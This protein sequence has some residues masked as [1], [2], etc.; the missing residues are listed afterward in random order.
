MNGS[1]AHHGRPHQGPRMDRAQHSRGRKENS[2]LGKG[3]EAVPTTEELRAAVFAHGT[4]FRS[5]EK[6]IVP[7]SRGGFTFGYILKPVPRNHCYVD[8]TAAINA[9]HQEWRVPFAFPF[10]SLQEAICRSN[11]YYLI[12]LFVPSTSP[13]ARANFCSPTGGLQERERGGPLQ[14]LAPGQHRQAPR[15]SRDRN[16]QARRHPLPR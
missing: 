7:R 2:R 16:R 15:A 10:H 6:V 11:Y 13:V 12:W 9:N 5:K 3:G 8:P 14:G 4:V 1:T